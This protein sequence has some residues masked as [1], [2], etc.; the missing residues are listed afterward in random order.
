MK[1]SL[2]TPHPEQAMGK[3]IVTG[4]DL[5][6]RLRTRFG[7]SAEESASSHADNEPPFRS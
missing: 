5:P 1:P 2:R 6:A 7:P 3:A 4:T